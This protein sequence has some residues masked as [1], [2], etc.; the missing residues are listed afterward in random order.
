MI[1]VA[2]GTS[3]TAAAFSQH[4]SLFCTEHLGLDRIA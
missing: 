2:N 1:D 4:V 3:T